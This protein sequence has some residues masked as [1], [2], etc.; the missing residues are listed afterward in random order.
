M[1][2]IAF[3]IWCHWNTFY[4]YQ[5]LDFP[6]APKVFTMI[7]SISVNYTLKMFPCLMSGALLI[8]TTSL[9]DVVLAMRKCHFPQKLI[10][11]LSVTIRYFPAIFE[12]IKHIHNAMKLRTIPFSEK[13]ECF[14]VPFMMAASTTVEELSAAAV[15]RGIENPAPKTS[16]TQLKFHLVDYLILFIEAGFTVAAFML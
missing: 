2:Q 3:G 5:L 4:K 9:H 15:T 16:I 6:I 8:S 11:T 14:V 13:I 7:F 12:E 10:I 1:L